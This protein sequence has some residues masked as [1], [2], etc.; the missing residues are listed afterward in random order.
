MR[1]KNDMKFEM[2]QVRWNGISLRKW[3]AAQLDPLEGTLVIG[4]A[5]WGR[6]G[7]CRPG[8]TIKVTPFHPSN[9]LT[10]I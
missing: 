1:Y 4:N 8:P 5:Q 3:S 2:L 10:R 7:K 9:L 6:E